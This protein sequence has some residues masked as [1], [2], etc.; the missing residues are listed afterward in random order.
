MKMT[1][2]LSM[3]SAA[4][5]VFLFS[6]S[7]A[8]AQARRVPPPRPA[9][10]GAT[11]Q[12]AAPVAGKEGVVIRKIDA[13]GPV[14]KVRTP[15]IKNDANEPQAQARDWARISVQYETDA[16]WIDE[17]EFRYMVMVQNPKTSAYTMFP[18][19]VTYI[20]VAKG[21]R[22]TST[23]FLRP[24]TLERYGAVAWAGVKIY[25]KG[26]DTPVAVVQIP[27]NDQRPWTAPVASMPGVLLNRDQTPFALVAIDNYETIKPK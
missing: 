25:L 24:A 18:A 15:E 7:E 16:E 23:V 11:V 17:L 22:H 2:G 21:K 8:S 1:V 9:A 3:L 14:A 10:A 12:P 4:A 19:S 13:I 20:D 5:L 6:A 27:E 26:K